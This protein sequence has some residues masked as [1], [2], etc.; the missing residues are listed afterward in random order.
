MQVVVLACVAALGVT[1]CVTEPPGPSTGVEERGTDA[2]PRLVNADWSVVRMATAHGSLVVDV[3]AVDPA[4]A[5]SIARSLTEPFQDRYD[6]VLVHVARIGDP[7]GDSV[8]RV[9][10]T[11]EAGY[12][13]FRMDESSRP[14]GSQ[15][16]R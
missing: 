13:E 9:Q 4:D 10:W 11:R 12:V 3:E 8:R 1:G 14:D 15:T 5:L 6:E 16:P 7:S 2:E